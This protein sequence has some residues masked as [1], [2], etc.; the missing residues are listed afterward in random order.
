MMNNVK[1]TKYLKYKWVKKS[2]DKA[3]RIDRRLKEYA[4]E[5]IRNLVDNIVG[6]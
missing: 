2:R 3:M 6:S 4:Q 1:H 5:P